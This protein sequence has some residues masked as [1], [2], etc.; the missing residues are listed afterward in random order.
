MVIKVKQLKE[1]LK[2]LDN[3]IKRQYFDL[4]EQL[5][6]DESMLEYLNSNYNTIKE[7]NSHLRIIRT[8]RIST[9]ASIRESLK[10]PS[11][12]QSIKYH[13]TSG[14]NSSFGKE[15]LNETETIKTNKRNRNDIRTPVFS[16]AI[17]VQTGYSG[18]PENFHS[19]NSQSE[20]NLLRKKS[21]NSVLQKKSPQRYFRKKIKPKVTINQYQVSLNYNDGRKRNLEGNN[22][23]LDDVDMK[24]KKNEGYIFDRLQRKLKEKINP[25]NQKSEI[26]KKNSSKK[27]KFVKSA[28]KLKKKKFSQPNLLKELLSPQISK[29]KRTK[30]RSQIKSRNSKMSPKKSENLKNKKKFIKFKSKRGK[31]LI[32]S[33]GKAFARKSMER[34]RSR[35]K[36]SNGKQ[37]KKLKINKIK[38]KKKILNVRVSENDSKI[39]SEIEELELPK[40][41]K[42]SKTP[43]GNIMNKQA[44]HLGLKRTKSL[45]NK[46]LGSKSMATLLES[47]VIFRIND[48]FELKNFKQSGVDGDTFTWRKQGEKEEFR[49]RGNGKKE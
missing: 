15:R 36:H 5:K 4:K 7:I 12:L 26:K 48:S 14:N 31:R 21:K 17:Y 1:K 23:S 40:K 3:T 20:E 6:Q 11:N 42:R 44:S 25:K 27:N 45:V 30:S 9:A 33:L 16:S 2:F 24:R 49:K 19:K 34:K 10:P 32:D 37:K 13:K 41:F 35:R 43:K 22:F 28:S 46:T 38:N 47:Q 8:Q 18:S 29:N 39:D